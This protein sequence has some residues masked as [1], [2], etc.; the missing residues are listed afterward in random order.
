MLLKRFKFLRILFFI[1]NII[2]LLTLFPSGYPLTNA[3]AEPLSR[4]SLQEKESADVSISIQDNRDPVA[5]AQ[6][7][8]Y[9]ITV[10]NEGP[11]TATNL[12]VTDTLPSGVTLDSIDAPD[13]SCTVKET[14][15]RCDMASLAVKSTSTIILNVFAPGSSGTITNTVGVDTDDGTSDPNPTNNTASEDTGITLVVSLADLEITKTDSADP[16]A[17]SSN[18]A[19]T[20]NYQNLDSVT[21][22]TNVVITDTLPS[23]VT[24]N[25]ISDKN[26][27]LGAHSTISC[28]YMSL[29]PLA[30]GSITIS[31]TAPSTTGVIENSAT[32]ESSAYDPD[33]EN[34]TDTEQTTISSGATGADLSVSK[35]AD[36]PAV[37]TDGILNYTITVTNNGPDSASK[38]EVTDTL[39]TG[40]T[41]Y[42]AHYDE[43]WTC[44]YN[45]LSHTYNCTINSLATGSANIYLSILAPSSPTTMTNT[46]AISSDTPDPDSTNNSS[47]L[48]TSVVI[49][50]YTADLT[51]TKTDSPD[52]VATEDT[53]LYTLSYGNN[54]PDTAYDVIIQDILPP[55]VTFVSASDPNCS[56][57]NQVV[58]CNLG[59]I[60]INYESG[61]NITVTAPSTAGTITNEAIISSNSYDGNSTNNKDTEDTT[62]DGEAGADVTLTKSDSPDPV[63]TGGT[64]TYT[65]SVSNIGS[66]DASDVSMQDDLPAGLTFQSASGT[67]W[68][69]SHSSGVVTCDY[70]TLAANTTAPDINIVVTAP[71]SGSI[72]NNIATVSTTSKETDSTNNSASETTVVDDIPTADLSITKS[73]SPDPVETNG[74]LTYTI[75]VANA[76][77][78][79]A[80]NVQVE[81]TL[82]AGVTFQSASGTGWSCAHASGVVTCTR[83][84]LAASATAPDITITVT[85]PSSTGDITNSADVASSTL[86][87]DT[88]NNTA[89]ETTTV[90][91]TPKANLSITKSDSPDPVSIYGTLTYTIVVTNDG[92]DAATNVVM[93]DNLPSGTSYQSA[94][95]TGWLCYP[96]LIDPIYTCERDTLAVGDAPAI[97]IIVTAPSTAGVITNTATVTADETDT[98]PANNTDSEDTT[99]VDALTADLTLV[100]SDNIDPVTTHTL[101]TYTIEPTNNGPDD[102]ANVT[103]EDTL[104]TGMVLQ[105]IFAPNWDCS[106]AGQIITCTRD[107]LAHSTSE[108]NDNIEITVLVD[109]PNG[110]YQNE[111]AI[112]ADTIDPSPGNN[113]ALET[114]SVVS[115]VIHSADLGIVKTDS[116]DPVNI[117]A[118][119][120]YTLTATNQGLNK[121]FDV[122]VSDKLP[123]GVTF[124][125]A[126]GDGW[127]CQYSNG[128]VVCETAELAVGTPS[129]ITI[130]VLAPQTSGD[131]TNIVQIGSSTS[132]PELKDN[133][134]EETTTVVD[135]GEVE[136]DLLIT[137]S[138]SPDPV[139]PGALV[140]YTIEVTNLGPDAV[141]TISVSDL[142]PNGFSVY[143][144]SFD[145]NWACN[146][147]LGVLL[148]FFN[149]SL[150]ASESTTIT[151]IAYASTTAGTYENRATVGSD[152][153]DP[154]PEN[155]TAIET[156]TVNSG[157]TQS[158]DLSISKSDSP[159][160][161]EVD[162]TLTYT[163]TVTNAGPDTADIVQVEDTLPAGVTFQSASGTDWDCSHDSGVVTCTRTNL[164]AS[165]TAPDITI[166]VTA[167]SSTGDITN[168]A[169]VASI[170]QDP[171]PGNNTASETT[172]VAYTPEADLSITK[173]DNPDPVQTDSALTYTISVANAGPDAADSV[174]VEDTL[175]AGVTFQSASGTDWDCSHDSG[176]VTCTR[177]ALAASATAPDI[178]I[179]VT[180]PSST[181]D[182]T[183]SADVA[184]S[185]LDPD[186]G[187]NTASETTTVNPAGSQQADLSI[188][189]SDS[190]D[191]ATI[192]TTL[193]YTLSVSNAGPDLATEV[194]V[195]D[196]LPGNVIFQNVVAE[197]WDCLYQEATHTVLCTLTDLSIDD[198]PDIIITVVAPDQAGTIEN[199]ASVTLTGADSYDPDSTN[200][201][202]T[203]ETTL[204]DSS[205]T[206][207]DLGITKSAE[208]DPAYIGTTLT[209]TLSITNYGPDTAENLLVTDRLP[210]GM[211]LHSATGIGWTC[212][213]TADDINCTRLSLSSDSI[214]TIEIT[215][216]ALDT[217]GNIENTAVVSSETADDD[218]SNNQTS[219]ITTLESG[220]TLADLQVEKTATPEP[221]SVNARLTYTITIEN[222]GTDTAENLSLTDK[223]PSGITISHISSGDW[224]CEVQ[225]EILACT[226]DS[227]ENGGS[228]EI[229]LTIITPDQ[230]GTLENEVVVSSSTPDNDTTNN[231]DAVTTTIETATTVGDLSI[232]SQITGGDPSPD[233]TIILQIAVT[234]NGPDSANNI[235]LI[236]TLPEGAVINSVSREAVTCT[237]SDGVL[238]CEL[239]SLTAS[240]TALIEIMM[241]MGGQ[242]GEFSNEALVL[243]ETSDDDMANNS[244]LLVIIVDESI[245]QIYLPLTVR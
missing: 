3:F 46:V 106:A 21:T 141:N 238:T 123:D 125:S 208:P 143:D 174:Q 199:T 16:V 235:L 35:T 236:D 29:A 43:D 195:L 187:N 126:H 28:S 54:G 77:P 210:E 198:A 38:V 169:T 155:N 19:S 209:Y 119:L 234:N 69:C 156:T 186:T 59:D 87:P 112:S 26:C 192:G 117:G 18:F 118:I 65:I 127:S 105:S 239:G 31:V 2:S 32:I 10:G 17:P 50:L 160:P 180:A 62:V 151:L 231:A 144:Y 170:T 157:P 63:E 245:P 27:Q 99:V 95:G 101:L 120:T 39:P 78:D 128:Y 227:L 177:S 5:V 79:A 225:G 40:S 207:A 165:A 114:T 45:G 24:V 64:L 74:T 135:P 185:T 154:N 219:L 81:D 130:T 163:I 122:V 92:P 205:A 7:F 243:A 166:T 9:T 6:P 146:V 194:S 162:G 213:Q 240:E 72:I 189:K 44:S 244:H 131:I 61:F 13:W 196:T 193:I 109:L 15:I 137:K 178:T 98:N 140:T 159:D 184:S 167:P 107:T 223:L 57:A 94:T 37:P 30:S 110:D 97:T 1:T 203:E 93:V 90:Q 149:G 91:Y 211:L 51:I 56:H 25:S 190:A 86:D 82:P 20:L 201:T 75:S 176:V 147:D 33:L 161:V 230:A 241:T 242:T 145:E 224:V 70:G 152:I 83:T 111:A 115:D 175:P 142:L 49:S 188:S 96:D 12:V 103:V 168:T 164:A 229:V 179:T 139:D 113:Q 36:R 228:D 55:G 67:G 66:Y 116:P 197:G 233:K 60:G 171:V 102:A 221:A 8:Y 108:I 216:V 68:S 237:E 153:T 133:K 76:G 22:A 173:S 58:T 88:G 181:G 232:M 148:C 100:K 73:D 212:T 220:T 4:D 34:S 226:K 41:F 182:I 80:D 53:L 124:L 23:G 52:P 71:P 204:S 121:A 89:S 200:N 134:H 183:N 84:A 172:T 14:Q 11:D 191:P 202:V 104:P 206:T 215:L 129:E 85:A 48:D 150:A 217:A 222:L 158:A 47:S 218:T 42:A 132:D 136:A 214:T 138:D